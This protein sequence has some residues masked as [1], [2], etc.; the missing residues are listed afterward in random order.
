MIKYSYTDE[1][2]ITAVETSLSIAEV[3]RKLNIKAVGGNYAT[4]KNKIAKLNL[5][6]SHF[7]GKAW[8]QG[9]RYRLVK[10]A[11]PLKEILIE[12]SIY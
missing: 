3:C 4:V 9:K 2:F 6:T 7:T 12:N 8:N 11:I 1:Q 10:S 5:D